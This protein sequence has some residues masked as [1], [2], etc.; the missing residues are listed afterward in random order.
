MV[1]PCPPL[2][3]LYLTAQHS[4]QSTPAP[5]RTFPRC[6]WVRRVCL[7]AADLQSW[8]T[9]MCAVAALQAG[10]TYAFVVTGRS[11]RPVDVTLFFNYKGSFDK[12]SFELSDAEK[13]GIMHAMMVP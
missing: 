2:Y 3:F 1:D 12:A 7:C 5:S 10:Q 9:Y 11:S 6:I 8:A 4:F 13:C